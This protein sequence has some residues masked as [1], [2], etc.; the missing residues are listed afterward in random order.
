MSSSI[1]WYRTELP[2]EE[3]RRLTSR[4]NA[5]A[6]LYTGA[7]L[8]LITLTG[9]GIVLLTSRAAWWV[10]AVLLFAHGTIF[11]FMVNGF[12][13][14]SHGTVFRTRWLNELF[15]R[16]FSFLG[17]F[18]FVHFRASHTRH[19]AY[20]LHPPDDQEVLLPIKLTV[21]DVLRRAIMDSLG[22]FHTLR[23]TVRI[24]AG[25]IDGKWNQRIFGDTASRPGGPIDRKAHIR[26]AWVLLIGHA[27][28][29]AVGAITGLWMLPVV[30]TFGRF[31][32]TWL[33]FLCN[34]TQHIGLSDEVDDFRLCCRSIELGPIVR[35]L[36][37]QM[38]Y[39]TEHHMYAAVPCYN[40]RALH[41]AVKHDLPPTMRGL[42]R[43]WKHIASILKRQASDPEYR[44]LPALPIRPI[45]SSD[46]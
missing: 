1:P 26:W 12:H 9:T 46:A 20:T 30:V 23:T 13:E 45:R 2:Q 37:W 3:L 6:F 25:R 33:H 29:I 11:N 38:N 39:H 42:R 31:Y 36:Y 32:G 28:I 44:Y 41:R 10:I 22:L 14:L 19:H 27:G 15:L 35:F 34:S 16:V 40:L 21:G 5:K 18:S 17:W 7:Y 4:S 8:G 43:T 24:A